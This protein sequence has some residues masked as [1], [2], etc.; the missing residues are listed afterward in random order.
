MPPTT[1]ETPKIA[2]N[3]ITADNLAAIAGEALVGTLAGIPLTPAVIPLTLLALFFGWTAWG[4][5]CWQPAAVRWARRFHG[6]IA[7]AGVVVGLVSLLFVLQTAT[8]GRGDAMVGVIIVS[9]GIVAP[10]FLV[11]VTSWACWRCLRV[12]SVRPAE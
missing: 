11:A 10:S 1:L 12:A 2:A 7:I 5:G 6:L 4:I 9:L 8:S 3:T